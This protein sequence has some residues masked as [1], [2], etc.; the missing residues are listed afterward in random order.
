MAEN[1]LRGSTRVAKHRIHLHV[2]TTEVP[3]QEPAVIM[4][5]TEFQAT[6]GDNVIIE[7]S[8][9]GNPQPKITWE[10]YGG[11]LL[12]G[13][14]RQNYGNL[15]LDNVTVEDEGTY[16][17]KANNGLNALQRE[18]LKVLTLNV[19]EPPTI[20]VKQVEVNVSLGGRIKLVCAVT[21]RPE[22]HVT[23]Y[24]NGKFLQSFSGRNRLYVPHADVS[25]KGMYQCF[26]DNRAG[27][28]H[29]EILVNVDITQRD[30][31]TLSDPYQNV[32][33]TLDEMMDANQ[34]SAGQKNNKQR[35]K[36]KQK[37][38]KETKIGRRKGENTR[39]LVPAKLV[40]PSAPEVKQL[41]DSSV[42]LNW[43]VPDNEGPQVVFF[44]VQYKKVSPKSNPK[45]NRWKTP[46]IE[47]DSHVRTF[48]VSGLKPRSTY[49]FRIA[50][51]YSNNN[52]AHSPNSERFEM[53]MGRPPQSKP[54][55]NSPI[56]VELIPIEF[57]SKYGLN[58]VWQY[59]ASEDAK[60]SSPIEGFYI[61]YRP[62]HTVD[63]F[64]NVT[65]LEPSVRSH[66]LK[67]LLPGTEY[68]IR[69]QSFNAAGN[70][71]FSNEAVKKTLGT[72][73][74][75]PHPIVIHIVTT[76]GQTMPDDNDD[77]NDGNDSD[78]RVS[79]PN[80][81]AS[82]SEMLY[83]VLG[84]VLGVI[85]LLSVVFMC[86]CWWKQRQQGQQR[87]MMDAM[88]NEAAQRGKYIDPNQRIYSDSLS[89]KMMN[90][91]L[92]GMNGTV[93]NGYVPGNN[94]HKMNINVNPLSEMET[95][96][97]DDSLNHY[98][99]T[100]F[101]TNG[102]F[103]SIHRTSDNNCNNINQSKSLQSSLQHLNQHQRCV[104]VEGDSE[105]MGG[106]E[107]MANPPSPLCN[108]KVPIH[109]NTEAHDGRSLSSRSCDHRSCDTGDSSYEDTGGLNSGRH[110]K[111]RRRT[112]Y[113][114][115]STKDQATN[116]DLSSNDGTMELA[117]YN[118][119]ISSSQ[120]SGQ[121]V[122]PSP[123]SILDGGSPSPGSSPV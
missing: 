9:T 18:G 10:K 100:S 81:K 117:E 14:Y 116:T 40:P 94:Y 71:S 35:H 104:P 39:N 16:I 33:K 121:M 48:E 86:M 73:L 74:Q 78:R 106:G 58:V 5:R 28:V 76:P 114:E 11:S 97:G 65:L 53:Q 20:V 45:E 23:W 77:D 66:L 96:H 49:K 109:C 17:C 36:G 119:S 118:K 44:R 82:N 79:G 2:I 54:P 67:D 1:K 69:M 25:S 60:A 110:R 113:K 80:A 83:M 105:A 57:Q 7:C 88:Q 95:L 26:A 6:V 21:G 29:A 122:D 123:A 89:K 47:I 72:S 4:P 61:H 46:D 52:N 12:P 108:N 70:S 3:S 32:T 15:Y 120:E 41:S 43:T 91:G 111:R 92:N 101:H 85:M 98:T 55:T 8:A 34:T 37:K 68:L 22:P 56:I 62:Y 84:I 93:V 75:T 13:R 19:S 31:G 90:G 107:S 87:R 27:M 63:P 64:L 103:P 99:S 30:T 38:R 42:M 50:A 115:Q 112:H 59:H 24:H 102:T 51:V